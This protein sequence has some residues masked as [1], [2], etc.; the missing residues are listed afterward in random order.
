MGKP[1]ISVLADILI[2]AIVTAVLTAVR[3]INTTYSAAS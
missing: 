3:L 1:S 2:C